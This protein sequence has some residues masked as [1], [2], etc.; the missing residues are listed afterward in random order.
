MF[1]IGLLIA[2][3]A[4][5]QSNS[6]DQESVEATADPAW[7]ELVA[8]NSSPDS[9][10]VYQAVITELQEK[11]KAVMP[12]QIAK[13]Y[14]FVDS[15]SLVMME[16]DSVEGGFGSHLKYKLKAMGDDKAGSTIWTSFVVS[17]MFLLTTIFSAYALIKLFVTREN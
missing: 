14:H 10:S 12:G 1:A 6:P 11:S 4:V 16:A 13:N 7:Y 3:A 5:A 9:A 15:V 8:R 2:F 17:F